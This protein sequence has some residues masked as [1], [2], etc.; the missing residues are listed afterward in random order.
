MTLLVV[1]AVVVGAL[2]TGVAGAVTIVKPASLT[3][4][5]TSSTTVTLHWIDKSTNE[6]G[7]EIQRSPAK[8]AWKK[9]ATA[10]ENATA[11]SDTGL[12][13]ATGYKYRIR[14][15]KPGSGASSFSNTAAVTTPSGNAPTDTTPPTTPGGL[16][17]VANSCSV[18][19]L[20][21]IAST[22]I[23]GSGVKDYAIWRD[24][25]LLKYVTTLTT[26]DSGLSASHAYAYAVQARDNA[27]NLS[28][29]TATK[30]V[31]TPACT[32]TTIPPPGGVKVSADNCS[33]AYASWNPIFDP[34]NTYR[35]TKYNLY[36]GNSLVQTVSAPATNAIDTPLV[37]LTSY[38]YSVTAADASGNESA[39]ST[40]V[41]ITT[42]ACPP[43]NAWLK[44]V[45]G[46]GSETAQTIAV[47]AAGNTIVGGMFRQ[48]GDFGSGPITA[49]ANGDMF[50][51]KFSP[52][53]V[54]MWVKHFASDTTTNELNAVAT[55]SAGDVFVAGDF[56]GSLNLGGTAMTSAGGRDAFVAKFSPAG[57]FVWSKRYGGSR[58]D[59]ATGVAIDASGNPVFTGSFWGLDV[60][61][62]GVLLTNGPT[63]GS[64]ATSG[65]DTYVLRLNSATGATTQAFQTFCGGMFAHDIALD[66]A[67]NIVLTGYLQAACSSMFAATPKNFAAFVAKF[68]STGNFTWSRLF[69]GDS[70]FADYGNAVAVD[71]SG[72]VVATGTFTGAV[73][74]GDATR[75][76]AGDWVGWGYLVK[77]NASNG[78]TAWSKAYGPGAPP[79]VGNAYGYGVTADAKGYVT[80]VGTFS[81][82]IDFG[83]GPLDAGLT[84]SG[85]YASAAY[86]AEYSATGTFVAANRYT[87]ASNT[88]AY[89]VANSP[90]GAVVTG[91]FNDTVDFG[92]GPVTSAGFN[93]IFILDTGR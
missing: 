81:G 86:V 25:A 27:L 28:G 76:H 72:N 7:F 66:S 5:A 56:F 21:W 74:F 78:T 41:T 63:R 85:S 16:S 32:S 45:G 3:A 80:V 54:L 43:S 52:S 57:A 84:T 93:D 68:D 83:G 44:T 19:Q 8:T 71:S 38:T 30:S 50:I 49:S 35:V 91:I 90:T 89:D 58:D 4:T 55:D 12:A 23:G 88:Q 69:D 75:G 79:A 77:L 15:L 2:S 11:Y 51:A 61:F 10:P 62:G 34:N 53:R 67:G 40:A 36:R 24:G 29:K 48:T 22:D 39:K 31:T 47:D 42:L 64:Q 73:N 59:L 87:G 70:N 20:T 46:A 82:V 26:L 14:A 9:I 6:I 13:P 37:A 60:D 17:A 33:V 92:F 65:A 18:V 1:A